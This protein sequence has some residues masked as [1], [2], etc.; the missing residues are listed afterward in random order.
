M[1][2]APIRVVAEYDEEAHVWVADSDDVPG[3][4]AEHA[5]LDALGDMVAELVPLLLVEN[6]LLSEGDE[7]AM[8]IE[9]VAHA[10]TTRNAMATA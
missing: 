9:I 4:V 10:M 6:G 1:T 2:D 8:P 7:P 5:D 3:L